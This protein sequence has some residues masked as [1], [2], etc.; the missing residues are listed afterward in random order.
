MSVFDAVYGF[1]LYNEEDLIEVHA[2][3][4]SDRCFRYKCCCK[5]GFHSHGNGGDPF[6]NRLEFRTTH[7]SLSPGQEMC[8]VIDDKTIR[9]LKS[10]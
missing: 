8:I 2:Y 3:E 7:C 10:N 6:N 1:G 5:Q 9:K 4:M